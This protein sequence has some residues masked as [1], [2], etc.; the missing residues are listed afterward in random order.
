MRLALLFVGDAE[1]DVGLWYAA[2]QTIELSDRGV[3]FP[4]DEI[5]HREVVR[6]FIVADTCVCRLRRR[7]IL[8]CL[9]ELAVAIRILR[10][11]ERDNADRRTEHLRGNSARLATQ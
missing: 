6:D 7:E 2:R 11:V 1:V 9:G 3:D 4:V 5:H 8:T 10:G